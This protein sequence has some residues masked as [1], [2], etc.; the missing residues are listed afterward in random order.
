MLNQVGHTKTA[1][2]REICAADA[3][4]VYGIVLPGDEHPGGICF[5]QTRDLQGGL[6]VAELQRTTPE[7]AAQYRRSALRAGDLLIAL[8]GLTGEAV[9]APPTL[10]GANISRGVARLR[11][12]STKADPA[13]VQAAL[14]S[15]EVRKRVAA[16]IT[17]T[18]LREISI[19]ELRKVAIPLPPLPEQR[20]IAGILRTWDEAIDAA[21]RLI[22]AKR[23]RYRAISIQAFAPCHPSASERSSSWSDFH[24]GDVFSER[25]ETGREGD[26]LLSITMNGGVIDRDAVGRK[27]T[28]AADKSRYKRIQLG[29]IGYNTMR[30]WQGVC[31]LSTLQGIISPAYTIVRPKKGKIAPNYARHLFKSPR[32]MF[33]FQR[34]SQGLTSDTWN[35]K[36]PAFSKVRVFL[37]P[38]S[39]QETIAI[40]LD[41]ALEEIEVAVR[42]LD[43][44]KRQKRGL[45]QKLLT[46]EWRVPEE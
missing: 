35:L 33:D 2:L 12:N 32:M 44:L 17:G 9:I 37:P 18:S 27:D 46:G 1:T 42:H 21:S 30:M 38:V 3:P 40:A 13:Y 4:I 11:V 24:L 19:E 10:E 31:G 26:R 22:D 39:V 8:R 6:N 5:V 43:A 45:M 23:R 41:C 15:H 16:A 25:R 20:L 14:A 7:I 28:S 34:Y 36:F 29:D